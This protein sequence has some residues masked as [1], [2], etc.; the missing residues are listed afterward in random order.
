MSCAELKLQKCFGQMLG[1]ALETEK[2]QL[3]TG[4]SVGSWS[5]CRLDVS[6]AHPPEFI[7]FHLQG[8]GQGV[9]TPARRIGPAEA[10]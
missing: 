7:K 2:S 4:S 6:P 9:K 8:L 1:E 5:V 10:S 3:K